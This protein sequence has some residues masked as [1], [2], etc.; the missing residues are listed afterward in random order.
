[1]HIPHWSVRRHHTLHK[2]DNLL[3]NSVIVSRSV[4]NILGCSPLIKYLLFITT[5]SLTW[6]KKYHH[7]NKTFLSCG[8]G[9]DGQAVT[10]Q[11]NNILLGKNCRDSYEWSKFLSQNSFLLIGKNFLCSVLWGPWL[12]WKICS[13]CISSLATSAW[14]LKR[15]LFSGAQQ[16]L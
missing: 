1:M 16:F 9:K 5:V 12:L 8:K 10:S 14:I 6:S 7:Y 15:L 3:L 13:H 11:S 4:I 2:R